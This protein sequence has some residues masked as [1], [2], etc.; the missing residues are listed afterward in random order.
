MVEIFGEAKKI[1]V[2]I[3][4][5]ETVRGRAHCEKLQDKIKAEDSLAVSTIIIKRLS[6][7]SE[8]SNANEK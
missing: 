6:S 8:A 2:T 5:R 4:E 7:F 3:N 1:F